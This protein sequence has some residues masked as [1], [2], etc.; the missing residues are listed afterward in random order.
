[1]NATLEK[2]AVRSQHRGRA[3]MTAAVTGLLCSEMLEGDALNDDDEEEEDV[4]AA[5]Q[6]AK[7]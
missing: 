4:D 3:A 6:G 7:V 5:L 1:M 2:D